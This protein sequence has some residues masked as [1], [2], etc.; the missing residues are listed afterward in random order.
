MGCLGVEVWL[1][2]VV[3]VM[4]TNARSHVKVNGTLSEQF[5]KGRLVFI[6]DQYSAL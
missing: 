6:K 4:Y 3:Q 2:K 1:V 5:G